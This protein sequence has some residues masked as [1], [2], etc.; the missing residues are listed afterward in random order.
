[1]PKYSDSFK[2]YLLKL[3]DEALPEDEK[4]KN[5]VKKD[6]DAELPTG[7]LKYLQI[8]NAGEG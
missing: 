8:A 2:E 5:K 3:V 1:M 7:I 4:K 6:R